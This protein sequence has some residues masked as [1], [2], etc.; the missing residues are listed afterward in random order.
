MVEW[1]VNNAYWWIPAVGGLV[2]LV[3][4]YGPGLAKKTDNTVDDWVVNWVCENT[5]PEKV[6]AFLEARVAKWKK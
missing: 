1:L 6:K 2:A 5:D 4:K 3:I